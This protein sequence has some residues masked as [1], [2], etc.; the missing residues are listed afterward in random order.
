M[1]IARHAVPH[2]RA[3]ETGDDAPRPSLQDGRA[4][5][6]LE[7]HIQSSR[8]TRRFYPTGVAYCG[9]KHKSDG[10]QRGEIDRRSYCSDC[11][12]V[13]SGWQLNRKNVG[14][15]AGTESRKDLIEDKPSSNRI[16]T[17]PPITPR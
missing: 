9:F 6:N 5:G 8:K 4:G 13:S 12:S 11:G 16:H 3:A 15:R 1:A 10:C 7:K 17:R 14:S 2:H